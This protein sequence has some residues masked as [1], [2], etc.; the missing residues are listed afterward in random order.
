MKQY[1]SYIEIN[2][3]AE[4][5]DVTT[6]QIRCGYLRGVCGKQILVTDRT[7]EGLCSFDDKPCKYEALKYDIEL[8]SYKKFY[9]YKSNTK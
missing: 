8:C 5:L 3:L 4:R 7:L 2:N 6:A 9:T 1:S